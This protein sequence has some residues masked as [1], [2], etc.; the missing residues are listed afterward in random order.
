ML[1]RRFT[2][3]F[4]YDSAVKIIEVTHMGTTVIV[5]V[6]YTPLWATDRVRS[7]RISLWI[8]I[9]TFQPTKEFRGHLSYILQ[10]PTS[11]SSMEASFNSPRGPNCMPHPYLFLSPSS[12]TVTFTPCMSPRSKTLPPRKPLTRTLKSP[13]T[14]PRISWPRCDSS[15]SASSRWEP[16]KAVTS[17]PCNNPHYKH[18]NHKK[19]TYYNVIFLRQ[20]RTRRPPINVNHMD[21]RLLGKQ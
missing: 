13:L 8:V 5:V 16:L 19:F 14:K 3:R 21:A 7:Q 9:N 12:R 10:P 2:D 18:S 20:R 6:N 4:A 11:L 17:S 1:P 15:A